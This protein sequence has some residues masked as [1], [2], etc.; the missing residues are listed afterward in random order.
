MK[1]DG[2]F[3]PAAPGATL[4]VGD[5]LRAPEHRAVT[6]A[7]VDGVSLRFLP[8]TTAT[9]HGA[10]WLPAERAGSKPARAVQIELGAG[11]VSVIVPTGR[12]S[13]VGLVLTLPHGGSLALWHGAAQVTVQGDHAGVVLDV[14]LG[15]A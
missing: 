14:G 7:L 8:G 13:P 1:H 10:T 11:A 15:I 12:V 5:S 6:L 2:D 4:D 9:L 3:A